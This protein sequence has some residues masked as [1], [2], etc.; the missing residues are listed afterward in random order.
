MCVSVFFIIQIATAVMGKVKKTKTTKSS[1]IELKARRAQKKQKKMEKEIVRLTQKTRELRINILSLETPR[2]V[3]FVRK[4]HA[5]FV[6]KHGLFVE[7]KK[8]S[9]QLDENSIYRM[10]AKKK[11]TVE[12]PSPFYHKQMLL[13]PEE[14][15]LTI[16]NFSDSIAD[17]GSLL[18]TNA[19][20]S[21]F[22]S[23]SESL[24]DHVEQRIKHFGDVVRAHPKYIEYNDDICVHMKTHFEHNMIHKKERLSLLMFLEDLI[25]MTSY[26]SHK[27]PRS[28][29]TEDQP[30]KEFMVRLASPEVYA[31]LN[32]D[33]TLILK[34]RTCDIVSLTEVITNRMINDGIVLV[35]PKVLT[36]DSF[37]HFPCERL[38]KVVFC[39]ADENTPINRVFVNTK[40]ELMTLTHYMGTVLK[41]DVKFVH[42]G[43]NKDC[44]ESVKRLLPPVASLKRLY[45]RGSKKLGGWSFASSYDDLSDSYCLNDLIYLTSL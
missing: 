28:Y 3:N 16:A 40:K 25:T 15:I 26:N 5:K 44:V 31:Q 30:L 36:T 2:V 41:A 34:S 35:T 10:I 32:S 23:K 33:S 37:L 8:K 4:Q 43:L 39:F 7:K 38:E 21:T 13:L 45:H 22:F 17:I 24:K 29:H 27:Y 18:L 6:N 9:R 42:F 19:A 11:K 20:F 14:V 12:E 1:K